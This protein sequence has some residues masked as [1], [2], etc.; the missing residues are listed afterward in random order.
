MACCC[1]DRATLQHMLSLQN[2][3]MCRLSSVKDTQGHTSTTNS[4]LRQHIC[5]ESVLT[6]TSIVRS[7]VIVGRGP[8]YCA[9]TLCWSNALAQGEERN[10]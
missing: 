10:W 2:D 9:E 5:A 7:F 8:V 1:A 4:D 6:S 3:L